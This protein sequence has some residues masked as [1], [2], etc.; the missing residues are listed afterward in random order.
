MPGGCALPLP[1]ARG[2]Y[3][4]ITWP[5]TW[6]RPLFPAHAGV[7]PVEYAV[8]NGPAA[9]PRARGG[10]FLIT[11]PTT[12]C[13]PLF[14]AHAG[15]FPVEYAV[16]NGP[17]ALPRARGGIS[18]ICR[19]RMSIRVSSPRTRGYFREGT[20]EISSQML[21]PAHAGV[22]PKPVNSS[23]SISP[24]PRARGGIS[25]R[26]NLRHGQQGSSPRTRGY[27]QSGK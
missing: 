23:R 19:P 9:L 15:V 3:F 26:G 21:F 10:Y 2:G 27:F 24:L 11:W 13:R 12:W 1:R 20:V 6:C 7:F 25:V 8:K 22:F 17:A 18:E 14:P 5:T 4:L 16:K